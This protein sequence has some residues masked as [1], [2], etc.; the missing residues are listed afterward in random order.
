MRDEL[1]VEIEALISASIEELSIELVE[2]NIKHRRNTVVIDIIAD[3]PGGGITVDECTALNKSVNRS[4]EK[5]QWFGEDYVVEVSSPGLDRPLKTSKD[6]ARVL[7]RK[8]RVHLLE[9]VEGK[10]E[11]HGDV[12]KVKENKI[13]IKTDGGTIT[14]PLE[15]ISMAVQVIE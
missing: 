14:I 12:V 3:K 1:I 8:V 4:I 6:F 11:H 10:V 15:C 13:L 7:E 5:R 2:F 9:P